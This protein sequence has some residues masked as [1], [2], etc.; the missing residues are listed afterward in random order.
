MFT[1]FNQ[2]MYVLMFILSFTYIPHSFLIAVILGQVSSPYTHLDNLFTFHL[3]GIAVNQMFCL[4]A[5]PRARWPVQFYLFGHILTPISNRF[6]ILSHLFLFC[7]LL[8][9][10]SMLLSITL[11]AALNFFKAFSVSIRV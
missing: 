9:I 2:I 11:R 6:A 4:L 3:L 8:F 1:L 7:S 5:T 10:P